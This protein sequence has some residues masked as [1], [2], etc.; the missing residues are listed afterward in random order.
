MPK[1]FICKLKCRIITH[2]LIDED[3]DD[4]GDDGDSNPP[5][6]KRQNTFEEPE[7]E[8]PS[9]KGNHCDLTGDKVF[10][11]NVNDAFVHPASQLCLGCEY[12][13][14]NCTCEDV[15]GFRRIHSKSL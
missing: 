4:S 13:F 12:T 9:I 14:K 11:S 1:S 3:G 2:L 10:W 5:A 6:L 15:V 8:L 7:V